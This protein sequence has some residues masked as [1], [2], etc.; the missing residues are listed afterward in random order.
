MIY[1]DS[2]SDFIKQFLNSVQKHG[3]DSEEVQENAKI[4]KDT[5]AEIVK[6]I[7]LIFWRLVSNNIVSLTTF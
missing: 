1:N 2:L 5:F 4:N 7:L 3:S 6:T